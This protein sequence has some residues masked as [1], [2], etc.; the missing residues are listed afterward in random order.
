MDKSQS[1][2]SHKHYILAFTDTCNSIKKTDL[3][4]TLVDITEVIRSCNPKDKQ[5]NG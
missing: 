1:L 3:E 2:Q 5:Y 4:D